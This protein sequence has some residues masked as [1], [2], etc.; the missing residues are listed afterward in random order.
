MRNFLILLIFISISC[1]RDKKKDEHNEIQN[2]STNQV[3]NI[4][5]K[6]AY[7]ENEETEDNYT[8]SK[9][10]LDVLSDLISKDLKSKGYEEP[11]NEV[12]SQKINSIFGLNSKCIQHEQIDTRYIV[13]HG[14]LLDGSQNT[15]THNL[16]ESSAETGNIFFDQKNK[17]LTPFMLLKNIVTI[18]GQNY[19]T[20]I[21]QNIIAQNKYLFNNSKADLAWLLAND[22]EFLK[23]LLVTFGYDKEEKINE[24]TLN[25]LYEEY[26]KET[27]ESTQKIGYLLFVKNC[28]GKLNI[29]KNVLKYIEKSTSKNNDKYVSALSKYVI[30]ILYNDDLKSQFSA[31]EKAEIVA[32]IS[33]IE[34]PALN[35]YKG[36]STDS[37]NS[38]AST[39][40]YVQSTNALNHPEVLDILKKHNYFGFPFLKKY[41]ESGELQE[42]NPSTPQDDEQ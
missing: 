22:K 28:D 4:F 32:Y 26:S 31:E 29:R 30:A 34:I 10:D 33:N 16:F 15:L 9:T 14:N 40:F 42:E 6:Q 13:Y 24:F 36:Q 39:L 20:H 27:P 1:S 5:D 25:E 7:L 23:T 2:M 17:L 18:N 21:P 37:W 11:S 38:Q 19:S 41:I 35:K 12:F 3:K 8:L